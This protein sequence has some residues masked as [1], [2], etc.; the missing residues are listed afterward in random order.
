MSPPPFEQ[1]FAY[2]RFFPVAEITPDGRRVLFVS[3]R[4]GQFNLWSVGID[5]GEA[6]Q[7][8]TFTDQAVRAVAIR[9]DGT[10]LFAADR[11]GDELHQL[12]RIPL[13]G[14]EPEQLTDL[15]QVQHQITSGAWSPDGKSFTFSAN[16]RT[17]ADQEI[18][19]WR[20]GDAEPRHLFGEGM[21]AYAVGWSPDG[22]KILAVEFRANTD[23]S[24][25]TIDVASGE[26][27][28]ATPHEGEIKYAPG[29][30]KRDSSG[31]FV[32]SDEG[33]EFSGLAFKPLG[34]P[35]E[36]IETPDREIEEVAGSRD[37][38]VLAWIENDDGW[39]RVRV[40][41]LPEPKLP[42]GATSYFGSG[43]S[44]S[45]DGSRLA[46][47]WEQPARPPE[48]YVVDT[49]TGEARAITESREPELVGLELR[50]PELIR[51]ESFDGREIPAWLYKP[52]GDSRGPF[53][54]LVH[55]GPESQEK[56]MYRP[57]VQYLLSRGIGVL[58]TNIRGS[59]G[60]GKTYQK[61]IHHDWG[62]GDLEDWRHA[63][64]WLKAQPYVDG[65]RL[66]VFGGSYG[67][68]ATLTCV[69]RLPEYWRAAVDIFGPSNMLTFVRSVPPQWVR[70][71]AQWVGD[72]ETEED[73]LR[74]R[75]PI[76]YVDQVRAALLV[77]QGAK[78]WRVAKAESD[79]M[80]ERLRELGRDVEYVVFEDEGHGFT[81]YENEV[82]AY[83]LTCEWLESHLV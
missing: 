83:R 75:S 69:T 35:L 44:V 7:L 55:G 53:A 59:T 13:E 67:G 49:A 52:D 78:D 68:F 1:F 60:Y 70:Y 64:E 5:G 39:A 8:T 45:T 57:Y 74:E 54:L 19:V 3:N 37:G 31:F 62:G 25:W 20:E 9:D 12:Y 41:G 22:S 38:S 81:R 21:A 26:A 18:F 82:R 40:R 43:L 24:L 42:Q 50:E 56:P 63:A 76:T 71:M 58:A 48:I 66:G 14:G 34:G 28:E 23:F 30:W 80:V 17:P 15:A 65:E 6:T 79:Q 61:L 47:V 29:P 32:L 46:I 10:I 72:P 33:R 51:Y 2:R 77:I 36:W 11:D 73:F 16:S 4:S 27:V